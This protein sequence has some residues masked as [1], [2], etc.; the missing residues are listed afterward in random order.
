MGLKLKLKPFEKFIVNGV[1]IENGRHRNTVTVANH[2]Q[3]MT[4]RSILQPE[5]ATTPVKRTYY[6][7]QAMLL[8]PP[9]AGRQKML[10]DTLIAQLHSAIMDPAMTFHL[11]DADRHVR[12]G[13]YYKALAA[14]RPVISYEA[15][16]LP[17][18]RTAGPAE[19]L[20]EQ[21]A[22]A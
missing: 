11:A 4:G 10:Y 21:A 1:V 5:E 18:A 22:G 16:L 17:S 2:A 6:A 3:V 7:V 20:P 13:D 9:N 12:D 15:I 14:L 19:P 8:D